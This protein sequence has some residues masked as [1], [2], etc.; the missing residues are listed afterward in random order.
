[1]LPLGQCYQN[2]RYQEGG[3]LW[4]PVHIVEVARDEEEC[5]RADN[6]ALVANNQGSVERIPPD[7]AVVLLRLGITERHNARNPIPDTWWEKFDRPVGY[8]CS[9]TVGG[10]KLTT[11]SHLIFLWE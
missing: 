2:S 3:S 7:L 6:I 5:P 8:C 4:D 10:N 9:L 11:Q 1:M